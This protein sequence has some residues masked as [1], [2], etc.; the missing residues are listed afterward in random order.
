MA[1]RLERSKIG[2]CQVDTAMDLKNIVSIL[3]RFAR[4]REWEQ[5]NSPKN[6]SMALS[7]EAAELLE[8]FQWMTE[9][10]SRQAGGEPRKAQAIREELADIQIYLIRLAK[11][12]EVDLEQAVLEK[13]EINA[14]KYPVALAKGNAIKYSD[15]E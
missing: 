14:R 10:Q 12:F 8:I 15:R 2:H 5:F 7:V 6:L 3:D 1:G 9:D 11:H 13:I 4:E